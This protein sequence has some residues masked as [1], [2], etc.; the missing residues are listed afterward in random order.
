[1]LIVLS[2]LYNV[3]GIHN[4]KKDGFQVR[5]ITVSRY[6]K[7]KLLNLRQPGIR[8]R[9]LARDKNTTSRNSR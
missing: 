8:E 4:L 2:S 9:K 5:N 3:L 1:M 6:G 7:R